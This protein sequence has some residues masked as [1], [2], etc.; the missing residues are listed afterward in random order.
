MSQSG[1]IRTSS[2]NKF[3]KYIEDP[4]IVCGSTSLA[5]NALIYAGADNLNLQTSRQR[6]NGMNV[7]MFTL[8]YNP[9][10]DWKY[11]LKP[12]ETNPLLLLPSKE[13]AIVECIKHLDW[14][15]EGLLV[16]ALKNY[17]WRFYDAD[18]EK[19]YKVAKYFD[20]PKETIDYWLDEARNDED[21]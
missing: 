10:I 16:E 11:E 12:S 4:K 6:Y 8:H 3:D 13:R 7:G 1:T 9:D 20:V 5:R 18:G 2:F 15:D 14:V 17:L 21:D 19:L